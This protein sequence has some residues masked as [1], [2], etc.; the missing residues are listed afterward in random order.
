MFSEKIAQ[1]K[2]SYD[3]PSSKNKGNL[4]KKYESFVD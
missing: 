3:Q 4:P 1:L 2:K